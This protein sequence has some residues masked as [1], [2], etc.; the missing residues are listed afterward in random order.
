LSLWHSDRYKIY[1]RH[2]K[3]KRAFKRKEWTQEYLAS[4]VGIETRQPIWKFFRQTIERHIF[5]EICFRL[6]L[7]WQ[8]IASLPSESQPI[9]EQD[10]CG[11]LGGLVQKCEHIVI[12]FK[13]SVALYVVGYCPTD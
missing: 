5:L 12:R 13:P 7:D 4:E 1:F 6:D 9:E 11:D 2:R 8:E 3:A 10:N